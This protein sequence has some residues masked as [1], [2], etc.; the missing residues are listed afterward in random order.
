MRKLAFDILNQEADVKTLRG[1][2]LL[3]AG[4]IA[5]A[6]RQFVEAVELG[7]VRADDSAAGLAVGTTLLPAQAAH[8]PTPAHLLNLHA[9]PL[10]TTR[11]RWIEEAAR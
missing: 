7:R 9:L 6:R 5:G 4:D 8:L 1:W 10:A 2:L 3:E 11:L